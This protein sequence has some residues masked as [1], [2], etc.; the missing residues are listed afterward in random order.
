MAVS[1]RS[2][3]PFE[4]DSHPHGTEHAE[5]SILTGRGRALRTPANRR[6]ITKFWWKQTKAAQ[7]LGLSRQGLIKKLK[8]LG[9]S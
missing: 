3:L 9:V 1:R 8:R 6:G 2:V 4:G 7:A 5:V